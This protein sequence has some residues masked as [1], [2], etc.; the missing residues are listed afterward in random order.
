MNKKYIIIGAGIAG[1]TAAITIREQDKEAEI[2]IISG[3]S[4]LVYNRILL[5][6]YLKGRIT[7]DKLFIKS[8]ETLA[9]ENI[10]VKAKT[11]VKSVDPNKHE[12]ILDNGEILGFDKLL[13]ATGGHPKSW[14]VPGADKQGVFCLKTLADA[15]EILKY[16]PTA[17][18][19]AVVGGGFIS[20]DLLDVFIN[21]K[22]ETHLFL[23]GPYYWSQVM[24][25]E[26]GARLANKISGQ[27]VIIHPNTNVIEVFGNEKVSAV[28]TDTGLEIAVDIIGY[29]IGIESYIQ[30]LN[31]SNIKVNKGVVV[32]EY[33]E[34]SVP[35]IFAAGDV[36]EFGEVAGNW[37]NAREQGRV[38]GLNMIGQK[39]VYQG[40][41]SYVMSVG[42]LVVATLGNTNLSNS[43]E[44]I[45]RKNE[46]DY[47]KI[48][49]KENKIIGAVF[50]GGIKDLI[51]IKKMI[52]DKTELSAEIKEKLK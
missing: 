7:R 51:M 20:L 3:E 34:S 13:I 23:R 22:M 24:D 52:L 37:D 35:D 36:A 48:L 44:I 30:F 19:A 49:L 41:T 42:G 38:A 5:A 47:I 15:D 39:T 17:K 26:Q 28:K 10:I 45:V 18:R 29:G 50:V 21:L 6:N 27:G 14:L 40:L 43:D 12:V 9:A 8:L 1:A 4:E 11:W 25:Q 31:N 33:L 32:N 16:T 2:F 46:I